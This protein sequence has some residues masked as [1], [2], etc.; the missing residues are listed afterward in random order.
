LTT[1]VGAVLLVMFIIDTSIIYFRKRN[2]Q[3]L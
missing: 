3:N 1:W 2:K